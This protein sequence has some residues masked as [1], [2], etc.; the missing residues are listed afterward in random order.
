MGLG[1][2]SVDTDAEF[3]QSLTAFSFLPDRI[4]IPAYSQ[5]GW[6]LTRL[7]FEVSLA[8][9]SAL[10]GS[11]LALLFRRSLT[12]RMVNPYKYDEDSRGRRFLSIVVDVCDQGLCV[13]RVRVDLLLA[14]LG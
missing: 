10:A 12:R 4:P 3:E 13:H 8:I 7:F 1:C 6:L 11:D 5:P 14:Q 9:R 2:Q